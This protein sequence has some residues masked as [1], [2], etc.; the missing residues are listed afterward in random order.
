[1]ATTGVRVKMKVE[2]ADKVARRLAVLPKDVAGDHLRKIAMVGADVIRERV[3]QK[4]RTNLKGHGKGT[5]KGKPIGHIADNIVAEITL[6][7]EGRR[8]EVSAGPKKENYYSKWV[9]FGHKTVRVTGRY[10]KGGRIYRIKKDLGEVKP[11][12]FMRPGFDEA[13]PDAQR[14]VAEEI[15]RRLRL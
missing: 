7:R 11:R 3:E 14:A 1:M 6:D 4:A 2:A 15:K 9:E 5:Y 8:V 12:P 10:K 13:S